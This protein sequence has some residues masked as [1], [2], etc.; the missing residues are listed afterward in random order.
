MGKQRTRAVRGM[1]TAQDVLTAHGTKIKETLEKDG[2]PV[3]C[4]QDV[5]LRS[6]GKACFVIFRT[7][8]EGSSS[9]FRRT[10]LARKASI[11]QKL[12]IGISRV[13]GFFSGPGR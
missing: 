11:F 12:D 13:K 3:P 10:P 9:I 7:V 8:R 5:A 2:D 1:G 4:R 6:F